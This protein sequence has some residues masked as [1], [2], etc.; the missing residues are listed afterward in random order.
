MSSVL[1]SDACF[2]HRGTELFYCTCGCCRSLKQSEYSRIIVQLIRIDLI[3]QLSVMIYP[4]WLAVVIRHCTGDI[5]QTVN[6]SKTL[7][8]SFVFVWRW[9]LCCAGWSQCR[10]LWFVSH[11]WAWGRGFSGQLWTLNL[12]CADTDSINRWHTL[13]FCKKV[14][15]TLSDKSLEGFHPGYHKLWPQWPVSLCLLTV[16][17]VR[18]MIL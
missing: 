10:G 8:L 2:P 6:H 13:G 12:S 1:G 7:V 16:S 18:V 17:C 3:H 14:V 5:Y 11:S 4:I 9:A 15:R